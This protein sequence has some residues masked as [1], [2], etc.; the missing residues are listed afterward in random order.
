MMK[1]DFVFI[2][3]IRDAIE[4]IETYTADMEYN[5]FLQS[6]LV[7]DGVIRQIEVI[8]EAAKN[9][10]LYSERNTIIFR[11]RKLQV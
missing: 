10:S 6:R 9:L 8:G 3:H 4:T 2:L 11:G 5:D 7:Q 1:D